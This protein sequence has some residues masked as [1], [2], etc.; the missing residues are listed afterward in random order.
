MQTGYCN[1]CKGRHKLEYG[2]VLNKVTNEYEDSKI[3]GYVKCDVNG[4]S[5]VSTIGDESIFP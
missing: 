3:L 2:K 4:N 1:G 5:Y